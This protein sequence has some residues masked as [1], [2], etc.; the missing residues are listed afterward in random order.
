MTVPGVELMPAHSMT[1]SSNPPRH[2]WLTLVALGVGGLLLFTVWG[3]LGLMLIVVA[4]L[5]RPPRRFTYL[6]L[7]LALLA[8][9]TVPWVYRYQPAVIAA[10][11]RE[12]LWLTQPKDWLESVTKSYQAYVETR[13]CHYTVLGWSAEGTLYYRSVCRD[14]APQM[15]SYDPGQGRHPRQVRTVPAGLVRKPVPRG[16]IL[17]WVRARG[18]H[19]P[20]AEPQVRLILVREP[21]IASPDDRWVA[22]VVRHV[23]G[24]EDVIVLSAS[25]LE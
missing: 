2:L 9:L 6:L 25:G 7:T 17:E 14:S 16:I 11:G 8:A 5:E 20:D 13:E 1:R 4:L 24:P 18:V 23:Y 15:W 19:P 3:L 22:V 21:G 12:M 10:P